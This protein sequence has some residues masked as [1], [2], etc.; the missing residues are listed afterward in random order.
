VTARLVALLLLA[1]APLA[2]A[3]C[4]QPR[5]GS[6]ERPAQIRTDL[7]PHGTVDDV[8]TAPFC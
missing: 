7:P 8:C 6:A 1:V 4:A 5:P 3:G 2:L